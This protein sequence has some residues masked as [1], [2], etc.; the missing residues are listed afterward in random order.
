GRAIYDQSVESDS[1][2]VADIKP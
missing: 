1:S 2:L